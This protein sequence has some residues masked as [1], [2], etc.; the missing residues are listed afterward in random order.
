M[1]SL[2][3]IVFGL[4]TFSMFVSNVNSQVSSFTLKSCGDSTDIAQ[5]IQ[6]DIDPKLPQTDYT[7][8]LDADLSK[9][10]TKGTSTYDITLNYIPFQPTVNDLCTEVANSN[11]TCP[12][13]QGPLAMQSK[14]SIPTGVSGIIVIKN[15][16]KND[17]DERI[18]CMQ[19][20]IKI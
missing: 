17:V 3:T 18:L 19:F 8:Y 5:N 12:L 15:E 9:E 7:L 14:G 1:P 2:K 4:M 11:I 6:L 16:W 20:T 13:L 10:V